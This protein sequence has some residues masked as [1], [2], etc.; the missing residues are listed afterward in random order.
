ME[1][2]SKYKARFHV[3]YANFQ[4]MVFDDRIIN[5]V[6]LNRLCENPNVEVLYIKN[7]DK[8]EVK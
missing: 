4:N 6:Q 1:N 7:L 5:E 8:E 3:R 2:M